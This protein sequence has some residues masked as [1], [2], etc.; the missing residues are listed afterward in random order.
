MKIYFI[1]GIHRLKRVHEKQKIRKQLE[2]TKKQKEY[3]V[4]KIIKEKNEK[5]KI[6]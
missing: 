5:F 1:F 4:K 6:K 3:E 2:V